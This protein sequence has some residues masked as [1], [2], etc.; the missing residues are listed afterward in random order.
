[1]NVG[2]KRAHVT[3]RT[4]KKTSRTLII[5][6]CTWATYVSALSL[7]GFL[8]DFESLPPRL[9]F[10]FIPVVVMII[11]AVF[12]SRKLRLA[13]KN[14]NGRWLVGIQSYRIFVELSLWSLYIT[15]RIPSSLTFEGSNWDVLVGLTAP[16]I[17]WLGY[18]GNKE[19]KPLLIIWNLMGLGL[20]I[21]IIARA[22]LSAPYPFRQFFEDPANTVVA[23]FP[24]V[25]LPAFVAP[26]ALFLHVAS[27]RRLLSN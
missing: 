15:G 17:A 27:L 6:F 19:R 14:I 23:D 11:W 5:I 13:I 16:F 26:F 12:K 22:V 3:Y 1:V 7:S 20:L 21:N 24:I 8:R 25:F 9:A 4:R 10:I 18:A 2:L